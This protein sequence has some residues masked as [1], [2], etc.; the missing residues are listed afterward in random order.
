M[1]KVF[2]VTA[3]C[4]PQRHYMV[5]ITERLKKIRE[6][7]DRGEYFTINRA[8]QYGK[9]TT[10]IA[11]ADY[12]KDDYQV[13]RIDFQRLQG[14]DYI[15]TEHF[16]RGFSRLILKAVQET[17]MSDDLKNQLKRFANNEILYANFDELFDI[18]STWCGQSER[19]VLLMIDEVDQASNYQAFLD[20]LAQLR[21]SYIDRNVFPTFQSVILA[22]V[23][24]IKNLK[25]R[26]V[27]NGEHSTNSPWNVAADFL[28]EMSFSAKEIAGMLQEYEND[29]ATGMDIPMISELI[30]D[31]TS[32]YPYLVSRICKLLDE[33]ICGT[34]LFPDRPAAWTSAGII[35]A[36]GRLV[37][38]D[39][40]L[41]G[42]LEDKV[43]A[44]P[45]LREFLQCLLMNGKEISNV[46]GNIAIGI[47][48]MFGFIRIENNK[49]VV[50][51]RIFE[52]R[53]YNMFLAS[54]EMQR[55]QMYTLGDRDKYQF[56]NENGLDMELILEHFVT[57]FDDLY[58]DRSQKFLEDDGRR[59]FLLYLRPIINGTGNYYIESRTRNQERTDVIVDYLGRQYVIELKIWRGNSYNERGEKQIMA[60]LDYYHLNKGYMISFNFNKKKKIGVNK[61]TLGDKMLIEAVV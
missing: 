3:N 41:F 54:A 57:I 29:Y 44:Y 58:G 15:D 56:I 38:E 21:A 40:T 12:L 22:G 42:S 33:Q 7:V 37:S 2:N 11:L 32:G 24:D 34:E 48:K 50:A 25:S 61:I 6:M 16:V 27:L 49:V 9:T 18:F 51:N 4:D 8:R 36:V 5:D 1:S 45:D 46:P 13:V 55:S 60:Y 35:E 59:Y 52:M 17:D 31:Y 26:F 53:L 43:N 28:V 10:L 19:P 30:Y 23:Y 20:L 47:A 39:N 14:T